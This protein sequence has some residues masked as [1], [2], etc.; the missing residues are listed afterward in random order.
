MK[1]TKI[2][3]AKEHDVLIISPHPDD[4]ELFIGGTVKKLSKEGRNI[5]IID[6]TEGE[7]S[8]RGTV[9]LRS[10]ERENASKI[11]GIQAR[12]SLNLPDSSIYQNHILS[13]REQISRV[14]YAIRT[15]K[16]KI[17]IAPYFENRHPDH[18]ATHNIIRD[19]LFYANLQKFEFV[20][21]LNNVTKHNVSTVL[22]YM[23]R[24][25]FTPSFIV[26]V[27]DEYEDKKKAIY[28]YSSQVTSTSGTMNNLNTKTLVSS[29]LSVPSIEAR[30]G[31]FGSMVGVRY[32]EPLLVD[33]PAGI[34]NVST[35]LE[36]QSWN[37]SYIYKNR[38]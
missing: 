22:W 17:I 37:S 33:A 34:S 35:Y 18:S 38:N 3:E 12:Y 23:C 5:C 1:N 29:A 7:M 15:I 10:E 21:S 19:A 27:T 4:A 30:D 8:T 26:D 20:G 9:E 28:C 25:E 13:N 11:L 16:P 31:Y 36:S 14:V 24:M 6:M 2:T 32:G